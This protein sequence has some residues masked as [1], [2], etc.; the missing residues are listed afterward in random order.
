MEYSQE[1]ITKLT[2]LSA[3]EIE[4]MAKSEFG[5]R[6]MTFLT[7]W[8]RVTTLSLKANR[9]VISNCLTS[10]SDGSHILCRF[11][12]EGIPNWKNENSR[13]H[14][15]DCP[16]LCVSDALIAVKDLRQGILKMV[17]ND[18]TNTMPGRSFNQ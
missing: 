7:D 14:L 16:I 13:E 10:D 1:E 17:D 12:G 15:S 8:T 11:C 2:G 5:K 3:E 9:V 18:E 4:D 6:C